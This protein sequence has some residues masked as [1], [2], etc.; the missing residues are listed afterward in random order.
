MSGLEHFSALLRLQSDEVGGLKTQSSLKVTL[1]KQV[2]IMSSACVF[3]ACVVADLQVL[4]S[5]QRCLC[6]SGC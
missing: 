5:L 2:Q 3:C 6:A 4:L 1:E